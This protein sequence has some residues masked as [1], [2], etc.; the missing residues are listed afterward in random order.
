MGDGRNFEF[1]GGKTFCDLLGLSAKGCDFV[2]E[3]ADLEEAGAEFL[4]EGLVFLDLVGYDGDKGVCP[5]RY[6]RRRSRA[7]RRVVCGQRLTV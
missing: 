3:D 1:W 4:D 2:S 5:L 7:K 6:V